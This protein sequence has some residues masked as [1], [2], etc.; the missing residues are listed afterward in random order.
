MY[1]CTLPLSTT[2]VDF[3]TP[4]VTWFAPFDARLVSK[5]RHSLVL[6]KTSI[7]F[8]SSCHR[9]A[10]MG[11]KSYRQPQS[12]RRSLFK[13]SRC[14]CHCVAPCSCF[15]P[16][17][18]CCCHDPFIVRS[19]QTCP[20]FTGFTQLVHPSRCSRSTLTTVCF[21]ALVLPP[22]VSVFF[23]RSIMGSPAFIL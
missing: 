23:T 4:P 17:N 13:I 2:S 20:P 3:S 15:V 8:P 14:I 10:F 1:V 22:R 7:C 6:K 19:A 9:R 21:C 5:L 12:W 16:C 11:S 18:C